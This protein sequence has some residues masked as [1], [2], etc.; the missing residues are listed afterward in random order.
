MI[1][2]LVLMV[3]IVCGSIKADPV[4]QKFQAWGTLSPNAKVAFYT[5]WTNGFL[6]FKGAQGVELEKCLAPMS[7]EH[8]VAMIEKYYTD[9][10]EQWSQWISPMI[11]QALTVKGGP[12]EGQYPL[13]KTA[14][15]P[16]SK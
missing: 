7:Y 1:Q 10:P 2:K 14:P 9:H 16:D 15:Q 3:L 13:E 11:L 5:G 12:C 6:L 4:V 8:A